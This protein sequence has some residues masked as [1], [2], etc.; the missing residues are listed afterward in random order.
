M[1]ASPCETMGRPR[2]SNRV[3]QSVIHAVHGS[4]SRR[5]FTRER[6]TMRVWLESGSPVYRSSRCP[7]VKFLRTSTTRR[8]TRGSFSGTVLGMTVRLGRRCCGYGV[9]GKLSNDVRIQRSLCLVDVTEEGSAEMNEIAGDHR[10]VQANG[11]THC[12]GAVAR[13]I[14]GTEIVQLWAC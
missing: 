2:W 14:R 9:G 10:R 13:L 5:E 7:A 3:V 6:D 12:R 11:G 1:G 8:Q 4:V